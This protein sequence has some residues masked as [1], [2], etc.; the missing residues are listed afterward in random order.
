MTR[1]V[2]GASR[3][4]A[5]SADAAA[6]WM[7][8]EIVAIVRMTLGAMGL[9]GVGRREA[10]TAQDVDARRHRFKVGRVHAVTDTAEVVE[11]AS[12][13]NGSNEPFVGEDVGLAMGP[14][15]PEGAVAT[16]PAASPE[17]ARTKVGPMRWSG[18]GFVDATPEHLFDRP[19]FDR[20]KVD[21]ARPPPSLVVGVAP[22][23][24]KVRL[25]ATL[26]RTRTLHHLGSSQQGSGTL[27]AVHAA[28][29]HFIVPLGD[30]APV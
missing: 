30:G 11:L 1:S 4:H 6:A 10:A 18:A 5:D 25:L 2:F 28:R 13:G 20:R 19:I 26:N 27:P 23:A 7:P 9:H 15:D 29:E 8:V 22:A 12:R 16:S 17:P 3:P 24:C 21:A 14:V